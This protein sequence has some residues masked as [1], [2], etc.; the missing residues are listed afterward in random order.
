MV[1]FMSDHCEMLVDHGLT[2]KGCRFYDGPC[3][4]RGSSPGRAASGRVWWPTA[5]C[6]LTGEQL[7]LTHGRSL[8]PI[9]TDEA[10]PA[11]HRDYVRS[12]YYDALNMYLSQAPGRHTPCW[13][14]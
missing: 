10:D 13:A 2:A 9:L 11:R 4:F 7:E 14:M 12:E 3:G 8:P 1:I 6:E 5:W